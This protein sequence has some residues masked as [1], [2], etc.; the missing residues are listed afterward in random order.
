L[1]F[2]ALSLSLKQI[3]APSLYVGADKK[4]WRTILAMHPLHGYKLVELLMKNPL[5]DL[6]QAWI[7]GYKHAEL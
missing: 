4:S 5:G 2:D 7:V 3:V 6:I 1:Y